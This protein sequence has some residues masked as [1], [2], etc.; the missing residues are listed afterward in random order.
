M[1]NYLKHLK[2]SPSGGQTS[3]YALLEPSSEQTAD[4]P[5]VH[6]SGVLES[7][8]TWTVGNVYMI[9]S[10]V[11]V[12]DNC[13]LTIEAGVIVKINQNNDGVTTG[14]GSTVDVNGSTSNPVIFTSY[15]DDSVGGDSNGDGL[16]AGSL[17]DYGSTFNVQDGTVDISH[18][19]FRYGWFAIDKAYNGSAQI[20]DSQINSPVRSQSSI[21]LIRNSFDVPSQYDFAINVRGAQDLSTIVL[22][23]SNSNLFSNS[24][25][26][27]QV[28]SSTVAQNATWAIDAV[29]NAVLYTDSTYISGTVN[30]SG[31]MVIK[32]SNNSEG[33]IVNTGGALNVTGVPTGS[34]I[35]TSYK[36]DS[37]G[38]DTNNDGT[39]S[40][41]VNDYGMAIDANG[42]DITVTN[43]L[44]R[45]GYMAIFK[46]RDGSAIVTN[47][48]F[49]SSVRALYPITL[50]NNTFDTQGS[51]YAINA[52]GNR[53]LAAIS[54]SGA[55]ANHFTGNRTVYAGN[56][57]IAASTTWNIDSSSNAVFY[58]DNTDLYGVLNVSHGVIIKTAHNSNGINVEDGGQ[59][60]TTGTSSNPV[61]FTS[62]ADDSVGGDTNDDG[63]STGGVND[64]G[65]AINYNGGA[66]DV[67]YATFEYGNLSID[68]L[69]DGDMQ[70][71]DSIFKSAVRSH[72]S[73][74]L[75][76]NTFDVGPGA[77]NF[78]L[79]LYGDPQVQNVILDGANKNVFLGTGISRAILASNVVV[80][81]G[82]T[83][84]I[85]KSTNA[86]VYAGTISVYG[87]L[88]LQNGTI[89]KIGNNYGVTV[90]GG[91]SASVN[92]TSSN[93]I[94]FTSYGDDS[95]GGDTNGDG[96]PSGSI[97][98]NGTFFNMNGGT[99]NISHAKF[100]NAGM[101]IDQLYSSSVTANDNLFET[102]VRSRSEIHLA[103]N[104]FNIGP[105][106]SYASGLDI[107]DLTDPTGVI[108]AGVDRNT[109]TG[110]GFG[111]V[112]L[113]GNSHIPSGKTWSID[114]STG[115]VL[116]PSTTNVHG[117]LN[118]TGNLIVKT[119]W[120]TS[121]Q[122]EN[123]GTLNV[124]GGSSQVL[125]TSY[126]NDA[127]GGDSNNDGASTPAVNDYGAAFDLQ[128]G[129]TL[130]AENL[131]VEYAGEA[132]ANYGGSATFENTDIDHVGNGLF[133][134][135]GDVTF[136]G[137]IKN[138]DT[139]SVAACDW[140]STSCS[141]DATYTDWG[142]S[143]GPTNACGKVLTVPYKYGG[144][145]H[146]GILFI[147]N[148]GSS[149]NPY[150][151]V[152]NSGAT[153]AEVWQAAEET[154]N[155][156]QTGYENYCDQ[157]TR[158]HTCIN[159]AI[160]IANNT[161]P[162]ML[163]TVGSYNDA[164]GYADVLN[165]DANGFII[166][167]VIEAAAGA[168]AATVYGYAS[169]FGELFRSMYTAFDSCR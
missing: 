34:I 131:K 112:L 95:A 16:S 169:Q 29:S 165:G 113:T 59:L 10:T 53:D 31:E 155:A 104:E 40:G 36:D 91:G 1:A 117:T 107:Q 73:I 38:G 8:E 93:P 49:N 46:T 68:K 124:D 132:L 100:I 57:S 75:Q 146:N 14:V 13:T 85:D 87:D 61:I 114:G 17:N 18:S 160:D 147:N 88:I 12:P 69:H 6:K 48:T 168:K 66:V 92:G 116:L 72:A 130:N 27:V 120:G 82:F 30:I 74:T 102:P 28:Q 21:A 45:N 111:K 44:F 77:T 103:R 134:P 55:T 11:Y 81:S 143:S 121:F 140:F 78:A 162:F 19:I 157:V 101:A 135:N 56:A 126:K 20:T 139:N 133:V 47:S 105:D 123:G 86:V 106:A 4:L 156:Q 122:V 164:A 35:F 144:T 150:Q 138:V 58:A 166:S 37:V 80:P 41:S 108:L 98:E 43:A 159:G 99:L 163:T 5:V 63:V 76:R 167:H 142:N 15:R 71:T 39:S 152:Q 32:V 136:R 42:G 23:G 70:I 153:F 33:F 83:W 24:K 64:Y 62:Y 125:M 96:A 60:D 161:S 94:T 90:Y 145:D 154:C 67:A 119:V 129:G 65:A 50:Q 89:F 3:T 84:I 51:A 110:S 25:R 148:C 127:A 128:S 151:Q 115:V 79:D 149:A 97:K 52:Y 7:C 22:A 118:L 109:F 2:A 54:L 137:S 158:M 9:D 26:V 141:V